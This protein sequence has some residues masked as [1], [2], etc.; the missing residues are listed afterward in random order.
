MQID[1]NDS[2]KLLEYVRRRLK[3]IRRKLA[4]VRRRKESQL[5][6]ND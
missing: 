1:R 5:E 3:E 6:Q 2:R 4:E